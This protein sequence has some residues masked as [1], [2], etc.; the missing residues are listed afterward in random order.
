MKCYYFV[1][2]FQVNA[3]YYDQFSSWSKE[4][5]QV[6][7]VCD[8]TNCNEERLG[9]VACIEL[10]VRHFNIQDNLI[11]IGGYVGHG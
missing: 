6:Q 2:L 3:K 5:S 10:A 1:T 7:L 9:A 11:V 8:G 4:F